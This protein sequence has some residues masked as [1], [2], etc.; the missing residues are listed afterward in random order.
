MKNKWIVVTTI[1]PPT[2]AI[3]AIA[4]LTKRGWS[5]VVVGDKKTPPTWSAPQIDFLSVSAQQS[6]FGEL[7]EALPYNHYCRKNLGYLYAIARGAECILETDDDNIPYDTFGRTT[8]ISVTAREVSG[9]DWINI[10]QYFTKAHIWPRGLP[11]DAIH[12]VGQLSTHAT[13]AEFPIQQ[14][15]ADLDPDVDAVYRLVLGH[16]VTFDQ[17]PPIGPRA[18]SFVPFNSQNTMFHADAFPLLYLPCHVSFRMTDIW[19]SFVAQQA[20][21]IFG[22]RIAFLSATVKQVR[23]QHDFT[24][25]FIDEIPG[26][27]D[28]KRIAQLLVERATTLT[29]AM[30]MPAVVRALW[31]ALHTAGIIPTAEM[32]ILDGWL[33]VLATAR[34]G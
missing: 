17:C 26:Y 1:N 20:L 4:E 19:R 25:D 21:W 33:T 9:A 29:P 11:L 10:Y 3:R 22:A 32:N 23:N 7:A 13:T 6:M 15:L 12:S 24:K 30:G 2:E 14:Y 8:D 31:E 5:A 28:N 16:E 34:K 27:V 18:G